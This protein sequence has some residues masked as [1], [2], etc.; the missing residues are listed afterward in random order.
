MAAN[1]GLNL[2]AASLVVFAELFWNPGVSGLYIVSLL[3]VHWLGQAS[4]GHE[5]FCHDPEVMDSNHGP[6]ELEV[7]SPSV[8]GLGTKNIIL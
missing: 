5:A 6:V 1:S 8:V 4:E 7:H 2:T 3:M